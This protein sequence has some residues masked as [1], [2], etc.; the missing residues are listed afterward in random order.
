MRTKKLKDIFSCVLSSVLLS[1][2]VLSGCGE[3]DPCSDDFAQILEE[4]DNSVSE[5]LEFYDPMTTIQISGWLDESCVKNLMAFLA[6]EYPS[7]NFE[8]RYISKDSYEHIIDSELSSKIATDVVMMTPSMAKKHAKNRYIEDVSGYCGSFTDKG[9]EAFSYGNRVYAVPST[10]DFQ[11]FFY[12]KDILQ[13]SQQT[14]PLSFDAFLNLC[15]YMQNE[16]NIKPLSAGLKDSDKVADT[17]LALLASGYLSTDEGKKFGSKISYGQATFIKEIRPFMYKWQNMCI[18]KIYTRSM[19]IMDDTAAIK[20][21]A[22]GKSFMYMGGLSDYNRI[23]EA[24]PDIKLGTMAISSGTIGKAVLIGGC[25]CGFAVNSFTPNKQMAM[26]VV[27]KIATIDGQ[28]ALWSDRQGSQTYL[29]NVVFDNPEEFDEIRA[30]ISTDRVVMPWNEW[31]P[32]SSQ[33]YEV[34]GRELQKVVLGERSVEVAFRVIDDEVKQ[35]L[36][37]D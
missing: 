9:K 21:F 30:L 32:H 14:T 15:D 31:G 3:S 35:I 12:N 34:F 2:G 20:E 18:H 22:S 37:E 6:K 1:V 13:K 17:A 5:E 25:S 10:S 19:C 28:R 7:Y 8:Y 27:G 4:Y 11:C 23:K 36:R 26:D 33:I 16:M 29:K 24:N